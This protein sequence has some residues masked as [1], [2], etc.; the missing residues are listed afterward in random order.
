MAESER[1]RNEESDGKNQ[2]WF[3][4]QLIFD[5][6]PLISNGFQESCMLI[7]S[8]IATPINF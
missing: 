2:I 1:N 4:I 7:I 6:F 8:T 3:Y 5:L